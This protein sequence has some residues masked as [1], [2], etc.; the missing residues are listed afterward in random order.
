M[1]QLQVGDTV[2][3]RDDIITM[4]D[5]RSG[6]TDDMREWAV[7]QPLSVKSTAILVETLS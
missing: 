1:T 4:D 2:L 6:L 5:C 3:I 7:K